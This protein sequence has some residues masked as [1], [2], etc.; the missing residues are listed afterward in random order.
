MSRLSGLRQVDNLDNVAKSNQ[1]DNI[2][3]VA[4]GGSG[5]FSNFT[6][7]IKKMEAGDLGKLRQAAGEH[8]ENFENFIK[9]NP[10]TFRSNDVLLNS[11]ITKNTNMTMGDRLRQALRANDNDSKEAAKQMAGR[12]MPP[13][14]TEK[15][16]NQ[17]DELAKHPGIMKKLE[18]MANDGLKS[19]KNNP[20]TTIAF[21]AVVTLFIYNFILEEGNLREALKQTANDVGEVG[22]EVARAAGETGGA[23]LGG[24]FEGM[25]IWL[26]LIGVFLLLLLIIML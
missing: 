8:F 3:S 22:G 2:A 12:N 14:E 26:I 20:L 17:A 15:F 5:D 19:L 11:V 13:D 9:N 6:N 18:D 21:A 16:A 23:L 24:V 7:F 4:K 10:N 1:I 25:G